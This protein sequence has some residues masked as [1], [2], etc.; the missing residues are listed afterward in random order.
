VFLHT[1]ELWSAFYQARR[2]AKYQ[3]QTVGQK[4]RLSY[5]DIVVTD[6]DTAMNK[7]LHSGDPLWCLLE[8]LED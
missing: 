5:A 2:D 1:R 8:D 7:M 6:E 4:Q 3:E